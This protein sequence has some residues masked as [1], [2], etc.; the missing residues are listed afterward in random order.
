MARYEEVSESL[1]AAVK[2]ARQVISDDSE[3]L[4]LKDSSIPIVTAP[5]SIFLSGRNKILGRAIGM[6]CAGDLGEENMLLQF[7]K[8]FVFQ[9]KAN[10]FK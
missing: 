2:K 10:K 3:D 4:N 5:S 1:M 9:F 6:Q 8:I 7:D